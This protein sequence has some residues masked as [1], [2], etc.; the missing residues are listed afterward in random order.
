MNEIKRETLGAIARLAEQMS[1]A[2]MNGHAAV[3]KA[4][5]DTMKKHIARL[6]TIENYVERE[7]K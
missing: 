5:F 7:A 4:Q 1:Y 6:E 2:A 3:V